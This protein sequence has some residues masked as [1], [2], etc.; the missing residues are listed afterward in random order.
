MHAG[1]LGGISSACRWKRAQQSNVPIFEM[2]ANY[3][4]WIWVSKS[5]PQAVQRVLA[6]ILGGIS[7]AHKW[8]SAQ[9]SR[10]SSRGH[11]GGHVWQAG[12]DLLRDLQVPRARAAGLL[13]LQRARQP[14][15]PDQSACP[16][17]HLCS[18]QLAAATLSW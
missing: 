12:A 16:T 2:R 11:D 10:H 13:Y 6:G 3:Q 9:P 14:E 18:V 5:M 4:P 17:R 7:S 1:A 8:D 15:R